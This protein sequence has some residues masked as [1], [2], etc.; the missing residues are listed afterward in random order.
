MFTDPL[1]TQLSGSLILAKRGSE[2]ALD[3]ARG[4]RSISER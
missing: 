4:R 1:A 3:L 2:K